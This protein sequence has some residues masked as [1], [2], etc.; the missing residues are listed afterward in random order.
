MITAE[1]AVSFLNLGASSKRKIALFH[2]ASPSSH[3]EGPLA[4]CA[5]LGSA[6]MEPKC[7][8][9]VWG[10]C[11]PS[12]QPWAGCWSTRGAWSSRGAR[13]VPLAGA[14]ACCA[15]GAIL[16]ELSPL[17]LHLLRFLLLLQGWL[18]EDRAAR[19]SAAAKRAVCFCC[20]MKVFH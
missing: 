15:P 7:E 9:S 2:R 3:S 1:K 6:C 17:Q 19:A 5:A 16:Q 4:T 12:H 13:P 14:G 11:F 8:S 18:W 20:P 10:S